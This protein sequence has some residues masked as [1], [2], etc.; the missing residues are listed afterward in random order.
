MGERIVFSI[1]D[2]GKMILTCKR[3]KLDFYLKPLKKM[4]EPKMD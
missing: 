3:V 2:I 4:N 1:S